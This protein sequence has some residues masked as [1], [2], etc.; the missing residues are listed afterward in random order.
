MV[1]SNGMIET[2][3]I[4]TGRNPILAHHGFDI[5]WEFNQSEML[6]KY[7]SLTKYHT[8][9]DFFHKDIYIA[10][11]ATMVEVAI[12]TWGSIHVVYSIKGFSTTVNPL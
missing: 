3:A 12:T 6:R 11:A 7:D 1:L 4:W 8:H 9:G 10:I 5:I 2:I